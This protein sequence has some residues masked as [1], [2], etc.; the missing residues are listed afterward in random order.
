[1]F[2]SRKSS[3]IY[4][5]ILCVTL[6][7]SACGG[8]NSNSGNDSSTAPNEEGNTD[9]AAP[10]G[11]KIKLTLMFAWPGDTNAEEE[12]KMIQERF[13][14]KYDITFKP[15]DNNVEKTIKTTISAGEPVDLAF[16]WP[17]AMETFVNADMALDLTPYLDADPEW[18]NSFIDGTLGLGTYN[19]K[20]YSV[21]NTPVYGLMIANKDLLVKAGVTLPDQPT[22][23]EFTQAL[24][25]IKEKLGITPFGNAWVGWT[26]RFLLQ[27]IWPNEQKLKEWSEGKIP[28]TDPAVV[29]VFDEVK[30]LYDKEFVYPGKGALT[31]TSD[32]VLAGFKAEKVAIM[33]YVNFLADGAIKDAGIKNPQ[34]LSWPHNGTGLKVAGAANGYMIPANV[35]NPEASVEVLKYLTSSEVLQYRVDHG[36]PVS[37]KDVK[38]ADPNSK[39]ELYARD[40]GNPT[41]AKEIGALDPKLDDYYA[42]K[43]PA[44]YIFK[45]KTALEE[46]DKLRQDAVKQ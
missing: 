45:G 34:I 8:G 23:E 42:N 24:S 35:K 33:A 29:K 5:A 31:A 41:I 36:A 28:F 18:K 2:L 14:D 46:V 12:Q 21:P 26:H 16:Y 11:E 1:M 39:V 7:V 37:V 19:G 32:Q 20:I 40:A 9:T 27:T 17:G 44:N 38:P 6:L 10:L 15:V 43:M 4:I 25:T 30:N 3:L 22:W 13:K